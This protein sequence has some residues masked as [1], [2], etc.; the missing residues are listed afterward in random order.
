MVVSAPVRTDAIP[1]FPQGVP[2]MTHEK[3]AR[4]QDTDHD[5]TRPLEDSEMEKVVGG[6]DADSG[7]DSSG[8]NPHEQ[9]GAAAV[10]RTPLNTFR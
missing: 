3:A 2:E 9:D 7:L 10:D 6:A 8:S 4:P 5:R 1:P